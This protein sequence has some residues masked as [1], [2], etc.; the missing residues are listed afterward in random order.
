[1]NVAVRSGGSAR[2]GEGDVELFQSGDVSRP[3]F[4]QRHS[5]HV[6]VSCRLASPN[7]HGR[8]HF[9]SIR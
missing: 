6:T 7:A 8:V 5:L 3:L 2:E 1:M 9:A 4:S